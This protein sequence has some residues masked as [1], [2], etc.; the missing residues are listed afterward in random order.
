MDSSTYKIVII[1]LAVSFSLAFILGSKYADAQGVPTDNVTVDINISSLAEITVLPHAI[2]WVLIT[3]GTAGGQRNLTIK[4]TGSVNVTNIFAYMSTLNNES[5]RP[6]LS[7][8]PKLYSAGALLVYH[9]ESNLT[10]F[11]AGRVEWNWTEPINNFNNTEST[12]PATNITAYGYFRN[13]STSFVWAVGGNAT[14]G[15]CNETGTKFAIEDDNDDGYGATRSP[16]ATDIHFDGNTSDYSFFSVNRATNALTGMCVAVN[17]TC[18]NIFVYKYDMRAGI[19]ANCL[20]ANYIETKLVPN[21]IERVTA[22]I[23]VPKGMPAG[24][25]S[26]AIWYFQGTGQP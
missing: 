7:S 17:K 15:W 9:N 23:Y 3:P 4:N 2:S 14:N 16:N 10:F 12:I 1:L 20:N 5:V 11:W 6:Y 24:N 26:Q 21:E 22:D 25:L 19:Y 8:D 13:A 18:E